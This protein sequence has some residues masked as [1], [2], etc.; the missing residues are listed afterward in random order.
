MIVVDT[1]R[2]LIISPL[3]NNRSYKRNLPI[4]RSAVVDRHRLTTNQEVKPG[5]DV[6][7]SS[8]VSTWQQGLNT[9]GPEHDSPGWPA[10]RRCKQALQIKTRDILPSSDT[11]TVNSPN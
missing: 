5:Q 10:D 7:Q 11:C 1:R 4:R 9:T 6:I 8:F 3:S 2:G